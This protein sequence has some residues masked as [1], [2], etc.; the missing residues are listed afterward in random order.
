MKGMTG[1]LEDMGG[2]LKEIRG[3]FKEMR[4]HVKEV[5][6]GVEDL[7]ACRKTAARTSEILISRRL[8]LFA[9]LCF[10]KCIPYGI[11]ALCHLSL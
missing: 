1:D 7:I 10:N 3:D 11:S 5:K 4:G 9:F 6:G 2:H 8:L